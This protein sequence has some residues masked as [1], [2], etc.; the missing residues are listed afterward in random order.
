MGEGETRFWRALS[1]R[2]SV[3]QIHPHVPRIGN[4]AT[5]RAANQ[6][7]NRSRPMLSH[8]CLGAPP[9]CQQV[10]SIILVASPGLSEPVWSLVWLLYGLRLLLT[11]VAFVVALVASPLTRHL[12]RLD[13][14]DPGCARARCSRTNYK[15]TRRGGLFGAIVL[16]FERLAGH[17]RLVW[18]TPCYGVPPDMPAFLRDNGVKLSMVW[19]KADILHTAQTRRFASRPP[20]A[21][22]PYTKCF[23]QSVVLQLTLPTTV[24]WSL[25][26]F[27]SRFYLRVQNSRWAAGRSVSE[28]LVPHWE[29]GLCCTLFDKQLKLHEKVS[30]WSVN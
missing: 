18:D 9:S 15:H 4:H 24:G 11:S 12:S 8:S 16:L 1:R 26:T 28:I 22:M 3:T 10:G 13:I 21:N 5:L 17:C 6:C 30:W 19:G 23:I 27:L 29:H 14:V 20:L 7:K 2:G 25:L